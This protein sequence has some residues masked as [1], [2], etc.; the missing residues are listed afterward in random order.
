MLLTCC[1]FVAYSFLCEKTT[2]IMSLFQ[3]EKLC[4]GVG[5]I[6]RVTMPKTYNHKL[7]S[8]KHYILNW[9]PQTILCTLNTHKIYTFEGY[10]LLFLQISWGCI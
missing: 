6:K 3:V 1:T 9:H 2:L 7:Q 8:L 10:L 4:H 5:L